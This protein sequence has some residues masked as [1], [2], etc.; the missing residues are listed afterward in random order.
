[1]V[2]P[3]PGLGYADQVEGGVGI[4]GGFGVLHAVADTRMD[5]GVFDLL[6]AGVAGEDFAEV[7]RQAERGLAGTGGAVPGAP[8]LAAEPG[9]MA[10]ERIGIT[11]AGAGVGSGALVEQTAGFHR[12]LLGQL[13]KRPSRRSARNSRVLA[14]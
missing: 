13:P 1:M 2:E 5:N 6:R 11:R 3:V 4:V 10:V 7:L 14:R 12:V 8:A 9:E